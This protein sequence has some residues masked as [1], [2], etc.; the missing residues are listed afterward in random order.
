[1]AEL[2]IDKYIPGE[3]DSVGKQ[4][5]AD[6]IR[7]LDPDKAYSKVLRRRVDGQMKEYCT[8]IYFI[9]SIDGK[10]ASRHWNGWGKHK[11]A[12]GNFGHFNTNEEL[13]GQGIGRKMLAAWYE[14]L[15]SRPDKPLAL[16]CTS[17]PRI[18]ATYQRYGFKIAVEG[19]NAPPMYLP[20][21]DSPSTFNA[22]C[23][24]YY[25]KQTSLREAPAHMMYRHE[26]DCLLKF[27]R[28]NRQMPIGFEGIPT[29]EYAY[30]QN[31]LDDLV[32]YF[33]DNDHV[34]GW[35][36]KTENGIQK[37]LYPDYE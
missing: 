35:G 16:F 24:Q 15:M 32:L 21:G 1:M 3:L 2:R 30:V 25:P 7:E 34:A 20:L 27:A 9:G 8:D 13:R 23:A 22:F 10:F 14:D 28:L 6:R 33:T 5:L 17:A 11:D 19:F 31:R 18:A 12:V 29:F 37:Q 4:L 26:I 36:L